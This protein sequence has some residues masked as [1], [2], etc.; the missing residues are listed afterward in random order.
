ML[1]CRD[2][3]KKMDDILV[4]YNWTRCEDIEM[5][6]RLIPLALFTTAVTPNWIPRHMPRI[7]NLLY[8]WPCNIT[9]L[10]GTC[11]VW[12]DIIPKEKNSQWES[13]SKSAIWLTFFLMKERKLTYFCFVMPLQNSLWIHSI[14]FSGWHF[15]FD[16]L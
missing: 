1:G 8:L 5:I 11:I 13:F 12:D 14:N 15:F 9:S 7:S 3:W 6:S 16:V 2:W 10:L 4:S